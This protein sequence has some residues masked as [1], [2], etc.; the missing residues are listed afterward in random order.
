MVNDGVS[1]ENG[2]VK[3]KIACKQ[4]LH[5][6]SILHQRTMVIIYEKVLSVC[7]SWY[8]YCGLEISLHSTCFICIPN[9]NRYEFDSMAQ[10]TPSLGPQH[11][12]I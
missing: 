10:L 11:E 12:R 4:N 8:C 2:K 5:G 1:H 3:K 7:Y 9:A 6:S